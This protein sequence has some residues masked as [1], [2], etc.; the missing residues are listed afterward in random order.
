MATTQPTT[1]QRELDN[2]EPLGDSGTGASGGGSG[3]N[4]P[5]GAATGGDAR[6]GVRT[7]DAPQSSSAK[8]E[9]GE[10]EERNL[11]QHPKQTAEVPLGS[12]SS[13]EASGRGGFGSHSSEPEGVSNQRPV[14]P[15][16]ATNSIKNKEGKPSE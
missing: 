2:S 1:T 13:P 10:P 6:E 4:L 12:G 7:P 14:E 15:M 16:P 9:P 5:G 8:A 11:T 3:G